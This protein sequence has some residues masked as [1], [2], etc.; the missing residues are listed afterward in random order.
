M[1]CKDRICGWH[2]GLWDKL[3]M[4]GILEGANGL[5]LEDIAGEEKKSREYENCSRLLSAFRQER[6][7]LTAWNT[8]IPE[9]IATEIWELVTSI[10]GVILRFDI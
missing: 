1:F 6:R 3:G 7:S 5:L 10:L 2:C 4:D 8:P 9:D